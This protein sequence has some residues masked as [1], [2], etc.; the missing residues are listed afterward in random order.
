MEF[1]IYLFSSRIISKYQPAYL[2]EWEQEVKYTTHYRV[3]IIKTSLF[4][5]IR[6]EEF[7][8]PAIFMKKVLMSYKTISLFLIITKY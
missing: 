2:M 4:R 3:S 1:M 7:L 6:W 5:L 8:Y